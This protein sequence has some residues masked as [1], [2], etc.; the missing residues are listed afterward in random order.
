MNKLL[1]FARKLLFHN[2]YRVARRYNIVVNNT[3]LSHDF[4]ILKYAP[5][6]KHHITIGKDCILRCQL[7]FESSMGNISIGDGTYIGGNTKIIS[8]ASVKIGNHVTIAWNVTIYDHDSHS[9]DHHQRVIDQSRQLKDWPTGNFIASKDWSVVP[10]AAIN[11]CD[12]AWIGFDAVILKGVTIGEG[13]IVGARSVIARD[14]APWTVVAG[15][16]AR[17][18]R[19]IEKA[20]T[21]IG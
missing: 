4:D 1:K 5:N 13:A 8:S 12:H 10:K 15:N 3:Y 11:I 14:V 21:Q 7:V 20:D 2:P 19:N 6:S 18:I 17:F 16:P 9:H